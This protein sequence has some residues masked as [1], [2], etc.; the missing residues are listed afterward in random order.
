[1]LSKSPVS[2]T[3]MLQSFNW[4]RRSFMVA[5]LKFQT[6]SFKV[7]NPLFF[8]VILSAAKRSRR[9]PRIIVVTGAHH[10]MIAGHVR[11]AERRMAARRRRFEIVRN[12]NPQRGMFSSIQTALALLQNEHALICLGDQ[13]MIDAALVRALIA[14]PA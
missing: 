9:I 8:A 10:E 14:Q 13:P 1:M 4:L 7:K 6:P 5:R 12:A 11:D 2:A 3:M